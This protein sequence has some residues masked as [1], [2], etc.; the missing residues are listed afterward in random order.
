MV[1]PVGTVTNSKWYHI[2]GVKRDTGIFKIL[3]FLLL[4]SQESFCKV[5]SHL[6]IYHLCN[7]YNFWVFIPWYFYVELTENEK[8]E[9]HG[10]GLC[11]TNSSLFGAI[12][13]K[14]WVWW[15]SLWVVQNSV[16]LPH[17]NLSPEPVSLPPLAPS[18]PP[19]GQSYNLS[20]ERILWILDMGAPFGLNESLQFPPSE[21]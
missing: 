4:W 5:E 13:T 16:S 9:N 2:L 15:Y 14:V 21:N 10:K 11:F 6:L 1:F 17:F 19:Q 12:W 18:P 20:S 3:W 8:Q 7:I